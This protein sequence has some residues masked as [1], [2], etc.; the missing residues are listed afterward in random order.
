MKFLGCVE[1]KLGIEGGKEHPVKVFDKNMKDN[2]ILL[3]TNVLEI[4]GIHIRIDK[5]T[6]TEGAM[7]NTGKE[8]QEECPRNTIGEGDHSRGQPEEEFQQGDSKEE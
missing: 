5:D 3:D 4:L 1:F 8:K 7:C 6:R 2:V